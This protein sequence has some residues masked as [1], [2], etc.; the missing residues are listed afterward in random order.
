MA[1]PQLISGWIARELE[2]LI[3]KRLLSPD[4]R[5]QKK[6]IQDLCLELEA[7]RVPRASNEF[8]TIIHGLVWSDELLV[9]R[10]SYKAVAELNSEASFIPVSKALEVESDFENQGWAVAALSRLG[11]YALVEEICARAGLTTRKDLILSSHLWAGTWGSQTAQN[12]FQLDPDIDDPLALKWAA[13]LD[14]YERLPEHAL[15]AQS[16][17]SHVLASLNTHDQADVAEYSVWA[18]Q[19]HPEIG[20]ESLGVKTQDFAAQPAQVRRWL[21][22]YVTKND[23]TVAASTDAIATFCKDTAPNAREGLAMGLAKT[24]SEDLPRHVVDWFVRETDEE[25]RKPLLSH[26][27]A[28][29]I[30]SHQYT[31]I[32]VD[33]FQSAVADSDRRAIML[34][35]ASGR[36]ISA[37]FRRLEA[38]DRVA[39]GQAD[40]LQAGFP[41]L[42]GLSL[43]SNNQINITTTGDV[44]NINQAGRDVITAE[45]SKAVEAMPES[46]GEMKEL[47]QR[48]LAELSSNPSVGA[49][50]RTQTTAA[51]MAV[52]NNDGAEAT[53]RLVAHLRTLGSVASTGGALAKI[54]LAA[55]ALFGAHG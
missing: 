18:L 47:L 24:F 32:V 50:L 19:R 6:G 44:S 4:A 17:N 16:K 1:A 55:L 31:E 30:R 12:S 25:V 26:M 20:L 53:Q 22:R 51:L 14:G 9:R 36:P 23:Q 52:A 2:F 5:Q 39:R 54:T 34:A 45:A 8:M 3:R 11:K 29:A 43:N 48:L 7:G 28:N 42:G 40:L 46:Q 21:Y 38:I 41:L 10:W 37:E 49:E 15:R 13:L 35:A 33:V 27:V